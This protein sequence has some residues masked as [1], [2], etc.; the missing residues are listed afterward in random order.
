MGII[1]WAGTEPGHWSKI[2]SLFGF[3]S[4]IKSS[5]IRTLVFYYAGKGSVLPERWHCWWA[6]AWANSL[7]MLPHRTLSLPLPNLLSSKRC[8]ESLPFEQATVDL[9][10]SHSFSKSKTQN[11]TSC[12]S[13]SA[14]RATVQ[15]HWRQEELIQHS[16]W[17]PLIHIFNT[18]TTLELIQ[19][20]M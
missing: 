1:T 17:A 19:A 8:P 9:V 16:C 4:A 11:I 20:L 18:N 15:I 14:W 5:Q 12:T 6:T 13:V 2:S 7:K 10:P 3:P